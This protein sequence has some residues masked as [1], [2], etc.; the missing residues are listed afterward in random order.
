MVMVGRRRAVF[1]FLYSCFLGGF[2][3]A[4]VLKGLDGRRVALSCCQSLSISAEHNRT[5]K[6]SRQYTVLAETFVAIVGPHFNQ[7]FL[8]GGLFPHMSP[9]SDP[10][11]LG[12]MAIVAVPTP[13]TRPKPKTRSLG[14]SPIPGAERRFFGPCDANPNPWWPRPTIPS[15]LQKGAQGYIKGCKRGPKDISRGAQRNIRGKGGCKTLVDGAVSAR[16]VPV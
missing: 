7:P 9:P 15:G 11:K 14:H 12:R 3:V 16:A 5:A 13:G 1:T 6:R 2:A 8:R 10:F 4:V